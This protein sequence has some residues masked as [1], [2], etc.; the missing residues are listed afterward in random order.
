M[1]F[2]PLCTVPAQPV[3]V[4]W[5]LLFRCQGCVPYISHFVIWWRNWHFGF[6][7]VIKALFHLFCPSVT[8]GCLCALHLSNP[9]NICLAILGSSSLAQC[10]AH[11]Q[12]RLL[13]T[14]LSFQEISFDHLFCA[15]GEVQLY[16]A[17]SPHTCL[18]GPKC[19]HP[20]TSSCV[21]SHPRPKAS[22]PGPLLQGRNQAG[23]SIHFCFQTVSKQPLI[24]N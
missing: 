20:K 6:T 2:I 23:T 12:T 14:P 22:F 1:C 24:K 9:P 15:P 5:S 3:F 21:H 19:H 11:S 18:P 13:H 16:N 4:G 7:D 10:R 8:A 17:W